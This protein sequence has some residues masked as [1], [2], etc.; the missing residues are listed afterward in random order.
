M[1]SI[2]FTTLPLSF[3]K[4]I[5]SSFQKHIDETVLFANDWLH[6]VS[7][8]LRLCFLHFYDEVQVPLPAAYVPQLP[9]DPFSVKGI[10]SYFSM[11]RS[12]KL[13]AKHNA[14]QAVYNQFMADYSRSY[15][16][17]PRLADLAERG[18]LDGR[19]RVA[20]TTNIKVHYQKYVSAY[21]FGLSDVWLRSCPKRK[22]AIG[23]CFVEL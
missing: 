14:F 16:S 18:S 12:K 15:T 19:L 17:A 13:H 3:D 23:V 20:L 21:V 5:E 8:F 4:S 22:V 9:I 1:T 10:R 6:D 11:I 2:R 7:V